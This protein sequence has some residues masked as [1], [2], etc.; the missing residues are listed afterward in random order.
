MKVCFSCGHAQGE[1]DAFCVK[2]GKQVTTRPAQTVGQ[3]SH[4]TPTN[5]ANFNYY[6]FGFCKKC[7][8]VNLITSSNC[9]FCQSKGPIVPLPGSYFKSAEFWAM[10]IIAVVCIFAPPISLFVACMAVYRMIRYT[11]EQQKER[12]RIREEAAKLFDN[13]KEE[14]LANARSTL[15][16]AIYAF[17]AGRWQDSHNLFK[18]SLVLG[19]VTPEQSLGAALTAYNLGRD[20][21]AL[22]YLYDCREYRAADTN[23]LRAR[24]YVRIGSPSPED[25]QWLSAIGANLPLK[26]K[27]QVAVMV[28][29]QWLKA[30]CLAPKIEAF[31]ASVRSEQPQTACYS[32]TLARFKLLA[33]K[34]DEAYAICASIPAAS[35]TKG[36]VAVYCETLRDMNDD[37]DRAFQLSRKY[38]S[39]RPDDI[40]NTLYCVSLAIRRKDV[41]LAEKM[42]RGALVSCPKDHRLRYHLALVLKLSGRLPECIA[43]LQDLLR[44]PES[45]GYRSHDDVRLLM[46]RCLIESGVYDAA[47]RQLQDM[48]KKREVLEL[49]YEIGLKYAEAGKA[50][51]ANDCWQEI[52][53]VD[54]RFKDVLARVSAASSAA[55]GKQ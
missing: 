2:C 35:H 17:N 47:V 55:A 49:L 26:L 12:A 51:K 20:A 34:T 32:E 48:T 19:A 31:I 52:Y 37:S 11:R 53:A 24:A 54:V 9:R 16:R 7:G 4:I 38:W 46:A 41:G 43:E 8:A 44:A 42:I 21:D 33:R 29:Q 28:A 14:Q 10:V 6:D 22:R 27:H 25:M 36:T 18:N 23:E 45:E 5:N 1:N 3:N 40:E 50:E 15:S 39:I 13:L 30:P